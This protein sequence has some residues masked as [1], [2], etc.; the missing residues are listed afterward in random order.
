MG[1]QPMPFS[2][3]AS[4]IFGNSLVNHPVLFVLNSLKLPAS[5]N[6]KNLSTR[7]PQIRA[8]K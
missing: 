8:K 4:F 6:R 5:K 1:S 2:V 7:I 3:S